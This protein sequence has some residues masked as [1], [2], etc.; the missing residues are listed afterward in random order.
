MNILPLTIKKR[1]R[2]FLKTNKLKIRKVFT[3]IRCND[4]TILG[5][6]AFKNSEKVGA[7]II[8]KISKKMMQE[9]MTDVASNS[10]LSARAAE[11]VEG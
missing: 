7:M 1:M 10:S 4:K 6:A 3:S 2:T 11:R 9:N 8:G 5:F